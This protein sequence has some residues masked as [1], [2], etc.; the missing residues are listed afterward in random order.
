MLVVGDA[1]H[2][3]DA[4]QLHGQVPKAVSH[5]RGGGAH[6]KQLLG[7]A[8]P[9]C[10]LL[11][12]GGQLSGAVI[13]LKGLQAVQGAVLLPAVAQGRR[14]EG[15]GEEQGLLLLLHA[16]R[17]GG[18]LERGVELGVVH[19]EEAFLQGDDWEE[20]VS[21]QD[22]VLRVRRP[23]LASHPCEDRENKNAQKTRSDLAKQ[24]V[25]LP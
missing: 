18:H 23:R 24:A 10:H 19:L 8:V 13:V 16:V 12:L 14:H 4:L 2:R 21:P 6:P 15:R 11:E 22:L 3:A 20:A 1:G 9:P 5:L 25:V 7:Q 17:R